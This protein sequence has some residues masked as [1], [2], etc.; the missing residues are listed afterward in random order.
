M[1]RHHIA[2]TLGYG[3]RFLHSTGQIHKGGPDSGLFLQIITDH[4]KDVPVPDESYT[5]GVLADAQ[6]QGDLRVF[7]TMGRRVARVRLPSGNDSEIM[8]L[9]DEVEMAL[10]GKDASPLRSAT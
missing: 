7:Q 9:A 4:P 3:P 2:T 6:A 8:R 5:F 1:E 10:P